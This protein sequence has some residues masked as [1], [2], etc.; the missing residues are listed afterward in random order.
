MSKVKIRRQWNSWQ[1]AEVDL[2]DLDGL[3]WSN[4]SGGVRARAPQFFVHGYTS[5]ASI[6]GDI[7]H[8]CAHGEGPHSIKV[9]I[10]KKDQS[11]D[12]WRKILAIA[13]PKPA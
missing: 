4:M 6:S 8:S 1:I 10:V 12:V 2:E 3:R 9:C 7:A 5:C 11:A 13:G